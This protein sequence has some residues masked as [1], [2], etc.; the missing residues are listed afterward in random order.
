MSEKVKYN[1][2]NS[3]SE[4]RRA[5]VAPLFTAGYGERWASLLGEAMV[6]H[7]VVVLV[8]LATSSALAADRTPWPEGAKRSYVDRCAA[9]MSSQGLPSKTAWAYCSCVANGMSSEFGMEE[10]DH[11]MKAE[12]NAKGSTYDQRLYKVMSGC[13]SI[14]PR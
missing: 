5:F 14:L 6:K 9:S 13:S 8:A 2:I 10:Y 7:F 4:K 3:D 1:A 11:M 12:P